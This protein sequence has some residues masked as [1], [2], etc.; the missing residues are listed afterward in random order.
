MR[1]WLGKERRAWDNTCMGRANFHIRLLEL[2]RDA[3]GGTGWIGYKS[4]SDKVKAEFPNVSPQAIHRGIKAAYVLERDVANGLE[5]HTRR[6]TNMMLSQEGYFRLIEYEELQEARASS[7]KALKMAVCALG[8]SSILAV[9]SIL[10]QVFGT[11]EVRILE[12]RPSYLPSE[13][14]HELTNRGLKA[15]RD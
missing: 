6:N 13:I 2:G 5:H 10:I 15:F 8:V 1:N 11:T 9:F 4:L 3:L 12:R 7:S 14:R